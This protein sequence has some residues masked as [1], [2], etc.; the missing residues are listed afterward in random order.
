MTYVCSQPCPTLQAGSQY[1]LVA[2]ILDLSPDHFDSQ[3]A[4]NWNTT[5]DY[6]TGADF[7]F[8]DTQFGA[9]WQFGPSNELRPA[10]EIEVVPEPGSVVLLAC[11]L[12]AMAGRPLRRVRCP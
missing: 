7:A 4:W 6:A 2:Q 5:L 11:G 10:F 8:N 1:W 3:S 9:G 12:A